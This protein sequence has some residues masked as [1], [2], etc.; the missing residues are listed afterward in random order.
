MLFVQTLSGNTLSLRLD[1]SATVA[2]VKQSIQDMDGVP[3]SEQRLSF[4]GKALAD[5]TTLADCDV[6]DFSTLR[7]SVTLRGGMPTPNDTG[8][9]AA[10]AGSAPAAGTAAAPP[11]T[12]ATPPGAPAPPAAAAAAAS[13]G[14]GA[15]GAGLVGAFRS[16]SLYIGD[17]NADVSEAVLFDVFNAIAP[18][19]SIRVCRHAITRLS[20][21]YAYLNFHTQADAE[22]VLDTMNYALIKGRPC[23]IMWSQRDPTARRSGVGNIFIKN[24]A[25]TIDSK[26][27]HDTFSIF[28][29]ILSCKV[30]TD[31]EGTSKGYGFVHFETQ[32]S[33]EEAIAKVNGME[34]EGNAVQVM[35]YLSRS[36]RT[37]AVEW[38]NV[39]VKNI[40]LHWDLEELNGIFAEFGEIQSAV[41]TK[42]AEGTSR[43]FGFVCF[44]E[45]AAAKAAVEGLQ[46]REVEHR[47]AKKSEDADAESKEAGAG[48]GSSEGET[49]TVMKP[50]FVG[51]AQKAEERRRMLV[52]QAES[53][54]A[55]RIRRWEG[56][57]LYIRN[58]DE[59]VDE[60]EL[61]REFS[62]FGSVTSTK[63][64]RDSE[65]R[66]RLF[67][68]VSFS[69]AEEAA[70]ALLSKNGQ[71]LKGKP[72]YVALWQPKEHRRQALAAHMA[73]RQVQAAQMFPPGAGRGVPGGAPFN[74]DVMYFGRM[75]GGGRGFPPQFM[76]RGP[77]APGY[78]GMAPMAMG[79]G[80]MGMQG[81]RG[82]GGGGR[83][84][85]PRGPGRGGRRAQ[86][87]PAM[88]HQFRDGARNMGGAS[89]QHPPQPMPA[90]A[91][92]APAPAAGIE[93]LAPEALAAATE[94]ERKNMIGERMFSLIHASQPGLAGKITGMLLDGMETSELLHLLESPDALSSRIKE[95][96]EVLEHHQRTTATPAQ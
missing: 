20:L 96:L 94:Q 78:Y 31:P 56:L 70:K 41:I 62:E 59:T 7:M 1:A 53:R 46:G 2:A 48:A 49:V 10:P 12:G 85:Y 52:Q 51:R 89:E 64:A 15:G 13:A 81:G 16:A 90:P 67:G 35:P 82:G 84:G 66:S 76:P 44:K 93:P 26:D 27:L 87:G 69:T 6:V 60:A 32:A 91:A 36:S 37:S 75:A 18:V 3:A 28:G 43:G 45:S 34:L 39:Y 33:A 40:P 83:R 42:D 54:R 72:L 55:D 77:M 88:P 24:L 14:A 57:N 22:R 80:G 92:A 68:F 21:G 71:I 47:E 25:P 9:E 50:L 30:S 61:A 23:R 38:T 95:A 65:N 5:A 58:L 73:Q 11:P 63:I 79:M 4:N 8:S 86:G 74:A 17:L 29:N 19:A